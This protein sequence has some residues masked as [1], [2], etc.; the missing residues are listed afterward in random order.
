MAAALRTGYNPATAAALAVERLCGGGGP[1]LPLAAA[2]PTLAPT[3]AARAFH[4][5]GFSTVSWAVLMPENGVGFGAL[6]PLLAVRTAGERRTLAIH[7]E[8]LSARASARAV[9][10]QR[11]RANIIRDVKASRG[12]S[13]TAADQRTSSS[14]RD[15]EH[16]VA[17]GAAMV[18]FTVATSVTVPSSWP[19]EDHAARLENDATGRLRVLR[20]E[21]AQDSAFVAAVLPVGIG[22]PQH[23]GGLG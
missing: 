2:G 15:Q 9:Q 17:A 13:T 12:F 5:D 4:H 23:R 11:Y 20:L 18:R 3:P 1:G 19:V 6:G 22:L 21:L 16:A 10:R 8:I 14:S 7:Y